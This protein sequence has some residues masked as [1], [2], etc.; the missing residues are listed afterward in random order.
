MLQ[1][2]RLLGWR[3]V[4]GNNSRIR[5]RLRCLSLIRLFAYRGEILLDF[6]HRNI[7]RI[8]F[9]YPAV[10]FGSAV[11]SSV[12][13]IEDMAMAGQ[14]QGTDGTAALAVAAPAWNVM[15]SLGLP[16]SLQS[17]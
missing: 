11:L 12:Y 17:F 8:Y 4:R 10:A 3:V 6:L 16:C 14:Y 1:F 15:Y 2:L 5:R 13:S 9:R 7:R